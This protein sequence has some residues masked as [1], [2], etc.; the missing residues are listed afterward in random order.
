MP[1]SHR[2]GAH[3]EPK[4]PLWKIALIRRHHNRRIKK[5]GGFKGIFG[6]KIRAHKEAGRFGQGLHRIGRDAAFPQPVLGNGAV[7]RKVFEDRIS[8]SAEFRFKGTEQF[9]YSVF[10]QIGNHADNPRNTH[11]IR[12]K[13][14]D[15]E[16]VAVRLKARRVKTAESVEDVEST[17]N[18]PAAGIAISVCC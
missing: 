10:V 5:R 1:L 9:L 16:A 18:R 8:P 6:T 14:A 2:T 4:R 17:E 11:R 15:N 13:G 12:N 3:N 7:L